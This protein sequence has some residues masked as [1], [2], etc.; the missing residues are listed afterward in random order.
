M[1]GFSNFD[2]LVF[3][4]ANSALRQILVFSMVTQRQKNLLECELTTLLPL[5]F[6]AE[7]T[8]IKR[9]RRVFPQK[10]T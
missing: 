10:P 1:L 3:F 6:A 4:N 2:L 8:S 9:T 5:S 7:K